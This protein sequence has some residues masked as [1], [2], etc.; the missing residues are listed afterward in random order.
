[1]PKVG[2]VGVEKCGRGVVHV[3]VLVARQVKASRLTSR[4]RVNCFSMCTQRAHP[5]LCDMF[6]GPFSLFLIRNTEYLCHIDDDSAAFKLASALG[7]PEDIKSFLLERAMRTLFTL[8]IN[9]TGFMEA[10]NADGT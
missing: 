7:N 10:R 2:L 4:S 6:V 5:E 3:G 8:F 1:M 9:Q